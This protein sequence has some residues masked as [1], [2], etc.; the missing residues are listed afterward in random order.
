MTFTKI[1]IALFA[2]SSMLVA[3][4]SA[5]AFPQGP[6][7]FQAKPNPKF[8]GPGPKDFKAPPKKQNPNNGNGNFNQ[9]FGIMLGITA[10]A[11]AAA[12]EAA[13]DDTV[14]W[15]EKHKGQIVLVCAEQ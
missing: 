4:T 12:A 9:A 8:P 13:D 14:C 7:N 2:A 3:G 1:S 5:M 15:K 6:Q 10:M 11:A